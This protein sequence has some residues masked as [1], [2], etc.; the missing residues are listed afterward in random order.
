M[1]IMAVSRCLRDMKPFETVVAGCSSVDAALEAAQDLEATQGKAFELL[2][3]DYS[4]PGHSGFEALGRMRAEGLDIPTI[5]MTGMPGEAV[6]LQAMKSGVIDFLPKSAVSPSSV[7]RAVQ[8]AIEKADLAREAAHKTAE[9]ERT[10]ARLE[11]RQREIESFYHNVSHELKTPLT[12]AREFVSLV[13]DGAV[14]EVS[15]DQSKLLQAA[16]GGCDQ[17]VTCLNDLL[18]A[19]RLDVGQVALIQE[20]VN[21]AR[22]LEDVIAQFE[23][24]AASAQVHLRFC[25][26]VT[27]AVVSVDAER[28][29]QAMGQLLSNAIKFSHPGGS[30]DVAIDLSREDAVAVSVADTGCGIHPDDLPRVFDRLY[31]SSTEDAATLRGLGMG[32]Y[33]AREIIRLHGGTLSAVSEQGAGSTFILLLPG[34]HGS[35]SVPLAASGTAR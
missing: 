21:L 34:R 20:P 7:Q 3:L 6:L 35:P 22:L 10:V 26:P 18:D 2:F 31:Q 27:S 11:Q 17:M 14:G 1:D 28:I 24:S 4:L 8:N 33:I 25:P 9:L 12:S 30:V 15:D 29:R 19:S 5:L 16:L 23:P 32:L 13:V